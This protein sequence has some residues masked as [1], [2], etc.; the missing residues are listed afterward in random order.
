MIRSLLIALSLLLAFSSKAQELNCHVEVNTSQLE[1]TNKSVFDDLKQSVTDYLNTNK[2]TDLQFSNNE[3]I[4]CNIFFNI[5]GYSETSGRMSGTIQVQSIR[6]VFNSTYTTTLLN[7]RDTEVE[8]NY[9]ENEPLIRNELAMESQLTQLLNFYAYLILAL[10]FDSFSPNGGS[11]FITQ[12]ETIVQQGQSSGEK[13]WNQF[14]NNR[15]RAT[16]LKA[17]TEANSRKIRDI[18]YK[19]HREGL[20]QMAMSPDKGRKVIDSTLDIL[21]EI[22]Q[23]MPMSGAL[24]MFHD[25]KVQELV[26]IYSKAPQGERDHAFNILLR[27]FPTEAQ[28][29]SQIKNPTEN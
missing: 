27:A 14:D 17:L 23:I 12:L 20:D 6:P 16:L 5:T 29:L 13:G 22:Q 15:N 11:P 18:I 25:S 19:Y 8:F 4:E 21:A 26:N 28:T 9:I 2:W 24:T 10:D 1:T 7:Y 3:R